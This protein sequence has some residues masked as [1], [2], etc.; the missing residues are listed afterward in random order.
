[1]ELRI[2]DYLDYLLYNNR[3]RDFDTETIKKLRGVKL[4]ET[5]VGSESES[6]QE[7]CE[8]TREALESQRYE[9]TGYQLASG[10]SW[11]ST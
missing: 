5:P 3:K 9:E 7:A 10:D 11:N 1:M 6:Y 8:D 4:E 2:A